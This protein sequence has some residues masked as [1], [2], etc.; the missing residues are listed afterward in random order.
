[1]K[2]IISLYL[3][4]LAIGINGGVENYPWSNRNVEDHAEE[5][6]EKLRKS[7]TLNVVGDAAVRAIKESENQEL[8]IRNAEGVLFKAVIFPDE[9]VTEGSSQQE[10]LYDY[11]V[12]ASKLEGWCSVLPAEYWNYE[13]CFRKEVSQFHAEQQGNKFVKAPVWSLGKIKS[14]IVLRDEPD[15]ANALLDQDVSS[16]KSGTPKAPIVKVIEE[17]EGGQRC[18]ETHS[19]RSI[20]IHIQCCDS[21]TD[22]PNNTPSHIYHAQPHAVPKASLMLVSEPSVCVYEGIVCSPLLCRQDGGLSAITRAGSAENGKASAK[23]KK[24]L[25]GL[26]MDFAKQQAEGKTVMQLPHPIAEYTASPTLAVQPQP[27]QQSHLTYTEFLRAV[28]SLCLV[29]QEEWWTYEVCINKGIRQIRFNIEQTISTEGAIVQKQVLANQY[30]LGNA[31]TKMFKNESALELASSTHAPIATETYESFL[32][33]HTA[34]VSPLLFAPIHPTPT[35]SLLYTDGTPCDLDTRNRSTHLDLVCGSANKLLVVTEERTCVYRVKVE[36]KMA[37]F[38]PGFM[39]TKEKITKI[40]FVLA[41]KWEEEGEELQEVPAAKSPAAPAPAPTPHTSSSA[42]SSNSG[43]VVET[44]YKEYMM[45]QAKSSGKTTASTTS[46]PKK[47]E[48]KDVGQKETSSQGQERAAKKK[49]EA[50]AKPAVQGASKNNANKQDALSHGSKS[51]SAVENNNQVSANNKPANQRS[52]NMEVNIDGIMEDEMDMEIL[53]RVLADVQE[54]LRNFDVNEQDGLDEQE[55]IAEDYGED[56][57]WE[58]DRAEEFGNL[59]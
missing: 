31:P 30:I 39:P 46:S 32:Y 4:S 43:K 52:V 20:S 25:G 38:L 53:E 49:G 21:Y 59:Q 16:Q 27:K 7:M 55:F 28:E 45:S 51:P 18:D 34:L 17:Y 9:P 3:L 26:M 14:T 33:N 22:L 56:E 48:K 15:L 1:M 6:L 47:Q 50:A 37:C 35:L 23:A 13:W 40:G 36:L 2:R 44:S 54:V 57:A 5:I 42:P 8:H 58:Y 12:L 19:K 41:E 24:G 10:E 29:K 11:N